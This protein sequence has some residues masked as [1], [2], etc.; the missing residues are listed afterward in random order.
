MEGTLNDAR[1]V[2]MDFYYAQ[3]DFQRTHQRWAL[4]LAELGWVVPESVEPPTLT[5]TPTGYT[6]SVAF[7]AGPHRRT[8]TIREDHR[9]ALD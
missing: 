1:D 5:S 8:R 4:S 6:F 2:A 7:R 9:L 3:R